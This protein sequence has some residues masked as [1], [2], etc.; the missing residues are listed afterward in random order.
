[1]LPD[2]WRICRR[3]VAYN[4]ASILS[5]LMSEIGRSCQ[6]LNGVQVIPR[7]ASRSTRLLRQKRCGMW[8]A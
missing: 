1:M 6:S 2:G 7:G 3:T 5:V 8:R 4:R